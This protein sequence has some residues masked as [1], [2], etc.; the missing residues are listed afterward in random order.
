MTHPDCVALFSVH[1]ALR[2][3]SGFLC[4]P[5]AASGQLHPDLAW[6]ACTK[7]TLLP[8]RQHETRKETPWGRG[9]AVVASLSPFA[10]P[11]PLLFLD[12]KRK[13]GM[14]EVDV[15]RRGEW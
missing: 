5:R 7:H 4:E 11:S 13:E 10:H 6:P 8:A 2:S 12:L 1:P 9:T 3:A 15:W 14:E